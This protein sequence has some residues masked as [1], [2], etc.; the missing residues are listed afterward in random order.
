MRFPFRR[1]VFSILAVIFICLVDIVH[2]G[3]INNEEIQPR[4]V[5]VSKHVEAQKLEKSVDG[6]QH[7]RSNLKLRM[8]SEQML[9]NNHTEQTGNSFDVFTS[10]ESKPTMLN[11]VYISVKT[12]KKFHD[13]RLDLILRTWFKLAQSQVSQE[14]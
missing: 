14:F 3:V 6:S 13:S 11:D 9:A 7:V 1:L 12:T 8:F 4:G 2:K 5:N 10:K